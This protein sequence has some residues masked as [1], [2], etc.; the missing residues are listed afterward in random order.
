VSSERRKDGKSGGKMKKSAEINQEETGLNSR[1]SNSEE[2]M[3][4]DAVFQ[5]PA[6]RTVT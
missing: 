3:A 1:N 5:R 4:K 6:R 2:R